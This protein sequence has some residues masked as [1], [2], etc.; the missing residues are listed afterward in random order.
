MNNSIKNFL[1]QHTGLLVRIDDIAENMNWS[2]MNK[3][4]VLFDRYNIKPLL[5]VIPCNKD[6]EL[7]SYEKNNERVGNFYAWVFSCLRPRDK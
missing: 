4:E 7:F 2:L 1:N 5:G 6:E 3:C